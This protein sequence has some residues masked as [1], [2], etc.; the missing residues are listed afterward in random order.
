MFLNIS[1]HPSDKWSDKQREAALAISHEL[2]KRDEDAEEGEQI[3]IEDIPFPNI[4]PNATTEEVEDMAHDFARKLHNEWVYQLTAVHIMGELTFS[5]ALV[6]KIRDSF[7]CYAATSERNSVM[8]ADGTKTV[9][10][11]FVQFRRY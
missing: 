2:N 7:A 9:H 8:N 3:G 1:N 11:D 4:P 6:N 5:F 10:F